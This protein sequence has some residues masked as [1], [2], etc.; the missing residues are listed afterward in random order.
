MDLLKV[1]LS[2]K[3]ILVLFKHPGFDIIA[4]MLP[5]NM[6]IRRGFIHET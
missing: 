3:Y 4:T 6:I 1:A 2:K 5:D